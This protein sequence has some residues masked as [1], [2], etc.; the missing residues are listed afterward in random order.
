MSKAQH[1]TVYIKDA[2]FPNGVNYIKME[3][4][5]QTNVEEIIKGFMAIGVLY[6]GEYGKAT[7]YPPSAIMKIVIKDV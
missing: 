3:W 4:V 2:D 6:G 5:N 1:I 7:F